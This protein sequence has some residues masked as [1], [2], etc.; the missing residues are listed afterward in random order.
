MPF[1]LLLFAFYANKRVAV[2]VII[3]SKTTILLNKNR[4]KLL[5]LYVVFRRSFSKIGKTVREVYS[6]SGM[7]QI[8]PS[9]TD[10]P[11]S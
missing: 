10:Q 11:S 3:L 1:H 2:A 9:A 4:V 8:E 6:L 5:A 7:I